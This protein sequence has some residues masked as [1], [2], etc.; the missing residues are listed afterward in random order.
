MSTYDI[1]IVRVQVNAALPGL[2]PHLGDR[3][4][5]VGLMNDLGNDLGSCLDQAGVGRGELSAVDSIGG[6]IFH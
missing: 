5:L 3:L 2:T 1:L 4:I 6:S